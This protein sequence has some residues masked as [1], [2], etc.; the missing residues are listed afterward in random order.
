MARTKEIESYALNL[1]NNALINAGENNM[2][3]GELLA[4]AWVIA[5]GL[6]AS[7][8]NLLQLGWEIALGMVIVPTISVIL[9]NIFK[10]N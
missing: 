7:N 2:A 10:K 9:I 1:Y 8:P 5:A 3:K 6:M 4:S